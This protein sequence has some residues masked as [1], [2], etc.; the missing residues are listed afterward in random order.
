MYPLLYSTNSHSITSHNHSIMATRFPYEVKV[1]T[2]DGQNT[3]LTDFYFQ[4]GGNIYVFSY[5]VNGER[6]HTFIDAG[7]LEHRGR[8]LPILR[9]HGIDLSR[10]D[11]IIITHRHID[12]C[13]LARDLALLSGAR[14]VVHSGFK[15]FVEG[16]L[17]PQEKVWLGKLNP[18]LLR[19]SRLEYREPDSERAA[20]IEGVRFPC[21][22]EAIPIGLTGK[23]E[24]LTC[25]DHGNTHT[26]DQL[27]V[28]YTR[29]AGDGTSPDSRSLDEGMIFSG[30]LWLM[31]GPVVDKSLRMLPMVVKLVF[32]HFRERLAG[33]RIVWNDPR[34]QD[35][36]AKDAL[37]KG[38]SLVRVK[39]GHG[40]EF[41]GSRIVPNAILADR[42]LLVK[43]GYGI[44]DDP[45]I[46]LSDENKKRIAELEEIAYQA[47]VDELLSW[48]E[49]GVA[50]EKIAERLRRIYLEQQGGGKLVAIDR[51]QRRERIQNTLDQLTV[52]PSV[53]EQLRQIAQQA[54]NMET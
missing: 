28:H 13:G 3:E 54:R 42:D 32:L 37:K 27:F 20:E 9:Q 5:E 39:P 30:D 35:I 29:L 4:Y 15:G 22:G 40:G 24:I 12:H 25:P 41:L 33:R 50:N 52:D 10:I 6:R 49:M 2:L 11:N 34:D 48:L 17:K 16:D 21:L 14:I 53:P 23:L 19:H 46:L 38:F 44:D 26:P 45:G 8:I 51:K 1:E 36:E 18:G 31:T 47:F 43:L 7:Y